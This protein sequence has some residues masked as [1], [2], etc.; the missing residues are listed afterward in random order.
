VDA[1]QNQ[2]KDQRA[3]A[4]SAMPTLSPDGIAK[5]MTTT[6]AS[7]TLVASIIHPRV[8]RLRIGPLFTPG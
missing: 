1:N 4:R 7:E 5:P 2:R 3:V 8:V 6:T